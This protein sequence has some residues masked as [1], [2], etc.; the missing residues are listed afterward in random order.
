MKTKRTKK[1]YDEEKIVRRN[2]RVYV[3][4]KKSKDTLKKNQK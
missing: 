2:G 4:A 3:I 1:R